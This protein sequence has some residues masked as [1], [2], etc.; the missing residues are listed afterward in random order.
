[1][2]TVYTLRSTGVPEEHEDL[3]TAKL[4]CSTAWDKFHQKYGTAA[5]PIIPDKRRPRDSRLERDTDQDSDEDYTRAQ[6]S[7]DE[8]EVLRRRTRTN[9]FKD[10][11]VVIEAEAVK[12]HDPMERVLN[13]ESS[14]SASHADTSAVI[15]PCSGPQSGTEVVQTVQSTSLGNTENPVVQVEVLSAAQEVPL[16]AVALLEKILDA[17]TM[18]ND[19]LRQILSNSNR[20]ATTMTTTLPPD[21][22]SSDVRIVHRRRVEIEE[23]F[24]TTNSSN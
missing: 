24:Q 20:N 14:E 3:V 22:D 19:L 10:V 15:T 12:N 5:F 16:T 9:A 13:T 18:S 21:Q 7:G 11:A 23:D 8:R 17:Q 2:S 4:V 1:M 6:E